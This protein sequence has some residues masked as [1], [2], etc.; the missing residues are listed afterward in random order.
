MTGIYTTYHN[1]HKLVL[2]MERYFRYNSVL[3]R[4]HLASFIVQV[5]QYFSMTED[6]IFEKYIR[7]MH[8]PEFKNDYR[9][10]CNF[11]IYKIFEERQQTLFAILYSMQYI[12][13]ITYNCWK[14]LSRNLYFMLLLI[15]LTMIRFC[16][17]NYWFSKI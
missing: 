1:M 15:I 12:I 10:T 6:S 7:T 5:E 14:G 2:M 17:N 4:D 8:N 13:I 16:K 3:G 11:N 9:N